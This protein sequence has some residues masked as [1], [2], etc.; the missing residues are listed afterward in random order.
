MESGRGQ[1][2]RGEG[3]RG[4]RSP[5]LSQS[6]GFRSNGGDLLIENFNVVGDKRQNTGLFS[7]LKWEG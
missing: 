4:I 2:K 6:L 7:V 1:Y 5:G 3:D